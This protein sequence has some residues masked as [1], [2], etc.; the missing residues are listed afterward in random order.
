M[1]EKTYKPYQLSVSNIN[2]SPYFIQPPPSLS[3]SLSIYFS[4]LPPQHI[5]PWAFFTF[6]YGSRNYRTQSKWRSYFWSSFESVQ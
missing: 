1:S 6:T 2:D 5:L 4:F 3:L